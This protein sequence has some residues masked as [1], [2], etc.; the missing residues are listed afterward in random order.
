MEAPVRPS[1]RASQAPLRGD[2]GWEGLLSFIYLFSLYLF[3]SFWVE[4]LPMPP[5]GGSGGS[6][7]G[8][9]EGAPSAPTFALCDQ[10]RL[11]DVGQVLK[12]IPLV[13]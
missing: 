8:E 12:T 11:R 6:S 5:W 10:F 4:P 13:P 9:R 2:F 1:V 7:S 3:M